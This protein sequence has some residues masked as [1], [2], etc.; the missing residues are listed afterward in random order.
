MPIQKLLLNDV[1]SPVSL[2]LILIFLLLY[3]NGWRQLHRVYP[4]LAT[5]N[6]LIVAI[7]AAILLVLALVAPLYAWSDFLMSARAVQKVFLC[8]VV[9]PLLWYACPFHTIVWG[10]PTAAR[11]W[12][13]RHILRYGKRQQWFSL[14]NTIRVVTQPGVALLAFIALFFAWHDRMVVGLV[15]DSLVARTGYLWILFLGGVV[16]WWP[17][18]GTGPR[19]HASYPQWLHIPYLL[20]VEIANM[21][22]GISISFSMSPIYPQYAEAHASYLQLPNFNVMYDQIATGAIVWV[23]GSMVYLSAIVMVL[24]E[25][26]KTESQAP[27][28]WSLD[29]NATMRT[30]APGLEH[31]VIQ[32][33]WRALEEKKLKS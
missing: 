13:T 5:R 15:M 27:P 33:R 8:M 25:L 1:W 10:L 17:I 9:P 21:S 7:E 31:R 12:I 6:R 24:Y 22:S 20:A 19:I 3:I 16:Y 32:N 2:M 23:T 30:I 26:F 18:M 11:H 28:Q 29:R 14:G 4:K